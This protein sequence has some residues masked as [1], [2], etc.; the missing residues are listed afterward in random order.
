MTLTPSDGDRQR[1]V[2]VGGSVSFF[3]LGATGETTL[4]LWQVV[5]WPIIASLPVTGMVIVMSF[6][7][8]CEAQRA[9]QLTRDLRESE[10]RLALA[11][12]A[13]NLG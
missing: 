10:Q 3:I 11:T 7:L 13:A 6:E 2:L 1:A 8:S 4:V 5:N 12:Y 9:G